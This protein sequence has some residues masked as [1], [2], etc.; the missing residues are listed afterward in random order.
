MRLIP[1][2]IDRVDRT[3]QHVFVRQHRPLGIPR[4]SGGVHDEQGIGERNLL[5][6]IRFRDGK[7][8]NGFGEKGIVPGIAAVAEA[9]RHPG[10]G[11]LHLSDLVGKVRR[12]DDNPGVAVLEDVGQLRHGQAKIDRHHDRTRLG[13]GKEYF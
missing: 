5:L 2:P 12:I 6:G 9:S 13:A 1:Q 8:G 3:E 10:P 4:R 7:G 11:G